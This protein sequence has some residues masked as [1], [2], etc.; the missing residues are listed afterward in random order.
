MT[1]RV[2]A[3]RVR[4]VQSFAEIRFVDRQ[5]LARGV[6]PNA[7]QAIGLQLDAH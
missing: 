5:C 7:G 1:K 4:G 2:I 6:T 3:D